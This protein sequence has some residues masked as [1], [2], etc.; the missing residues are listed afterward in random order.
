MVEKVVKQ[1][2]QEPMNT[3]FARSPT[4]QIPTFF[5]PT[6][7]VPRRSYYGFQSER[8]ANLARDMIAV[9]LIGGYFGITPVSLFS[10][11]I[12]TNMLTDYL[13]DNLNLSFIASEAVLVSL[14]LAEGFYF[15]SGALVTISIIIFMNSL[16]KQ[17]SLSDELSPQLSP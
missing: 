7:Y 17:F 13:S 5:Q 15:E 8:D 1:G 14:V 9:Y 4:R 3:V 11:F 16:L 10:G 12:L 6:L 2:H